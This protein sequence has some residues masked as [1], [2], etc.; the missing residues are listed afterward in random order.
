MF[1]LVFAIG[2]MPG[3]MAHYPRQIYTDASERAC[4]R[5]VKRP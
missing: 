3:W 2:R 4:V 1:T 5:L